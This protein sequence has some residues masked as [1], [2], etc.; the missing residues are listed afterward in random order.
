MLFEKKGHCAPIKFFPVTMRQRLKKGTP[1]K[2][3]ITLGILSC[4]HNQVLLQFFIFQ[5]QKLNYK[6]DFSDDW[7]NKW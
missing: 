2:S 7:L 1:G 4:S 6:A 5:I 3:Y